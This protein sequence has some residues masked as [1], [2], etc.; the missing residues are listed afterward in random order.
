[1]ADRRD[2]GEIETDNLI[3]E[4]EKRITVEYRQ[5]E[6]EIREK[7]NDYYRRYDIKLQKWE[8]WVKTGK[9]SQ[10]DFDKWKVGQLAIGK[11]WE[12]LRDQL[13]HDLYNTNQIARSIARGYMPE[14]YALNHNY[15]TFECEKGS[16][17]DTSY[18]LYSR[19]AVENMFRENPQM[20]PDPGRKVSKEIAEGKAIRWN[21][22][23]IQSVMTQAI[24]QGN[25]IPD[26]AT[27]LANAVGDSDRKAA[28]RNAR[29]M[30]TGAQNRGRQDAYRRAQS[31]GID[32]RQMW[33]AAHDM[34]TRHAHRQL[35]Y[36]IKDLDEPFENEFGKIMYPGDPTAAPANVYN[37][38]CA[39]RA[40]VEGLERRSG[41][42]GDLDLSQI[43]GMSYEEW[44]KSKVEKTKNILR[45]DQ[46]ADN[47]RAGYIREYAEN[48]RLNVPSGRRTD[49]S[50]DALNPDITSEASKAKGADSKE[51]IPL[52]DPT[53]LEDSMLPTV[54]DKYVRQL[55]K[56]PEEIQ[57][58]HDVFD[59][60]AQFVRLKGQGSQ[61]M[62][63]SGIV[64]YTD[65]ADKGYDY[66]RFL[67]LN[68]ELGH[69]YDH[70][71]DGNL[72]D[73]T[74]GETE[75]VKAATGLNDRWLYLA[76][77][78]SDKFL[79]AMRADTEKLAD[80]VYDDD[81]WPSV[82][83]SLNGNDSS[84]GMQD[85]IDGLFGDNIQ[86][87]VK[88]GHGNEY[89]DRRYSSLSERA[90]DNAVAQL[91]NNE[92]V[93]VYDHDSLR[94]TLRNYETASELWGHINAALTVGGDALSYAERLAPESTKA[95]MEIARMLKS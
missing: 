18:T 76:P 19:E 14:V 26:I 84:Q 41:T 92:D 7:V 50:I 22:N 67:T 62:P 24:L 90:R 36:V 86:T 58:M 81:L 64:Y 16:G 39:L 66:D 1:M 55:R 10:A 89:Y 25:S 15:G 44:K 47:A 77:S 13:A 11:R 43:E 33:L 3:A 45:P 73:L 85:F 31:K 87:G 30:A 2:P 88:W 54:M 4:I 83:T 79:A 80:L 34:R 29:T 8:E 51:M 40:V 59:D 23:H 93:A 75:A 46:R 53:T 57:F 27:R 63:S 38:R 48:P 70:R 91:E 32:T 20:L 60:S 35:D 9:K 69:L 56:A 42:S 82:R 78:N 6:R 72:K 49:L 95:Y 21:N 74:F 5:A 61:Y 17:I 12:D 65:K 94:R 71:I 68:H 28:I 52:N 37:C